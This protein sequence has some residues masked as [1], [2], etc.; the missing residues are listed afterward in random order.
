MEPNRNSVLADVQEVGYLGV[1]TSLET[2]CDYL[3]VDRS[4]FVD[5]PLK[6]PTLIG[7]LVVM[8]VKLEPQCR[9]DRCRVYSLLTVASGSGI[10]SAD[11][12][13]HS[14]GEALQRG[15]IPTFEVTDSRNYPDNGFALGILVI[16]HCDDGS[17]LS[18]AAGDA[19]AKPID[20]GDHCVLISILGLGDEFFVAP[21]IPSHRLFR[22]VQGGEWQNRLMVMSDRFGLILSK[23]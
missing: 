15:P 19:G 8:P 9:F 1:R 2:E 14:E 22:L 3:T 13:G 12:P 4:E 20:Q 11:I 16:R 17:A 7:P 5:C 6:A 23:N 10:F 21:P 18:Q